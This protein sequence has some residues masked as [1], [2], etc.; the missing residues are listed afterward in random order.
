MS[1]RANKIAFSLWEIVKELLVLLGFNGHK[2][3]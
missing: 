3:D 2:P 1:E